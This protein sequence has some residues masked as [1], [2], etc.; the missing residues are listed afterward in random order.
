MLGVAL[1]KSADLE[2]RTECEPSVLLENGFG[3][4]ISDLNWNV[5]NVL[6]IESK[7]FGSQWS[8]V[9]SLY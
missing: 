5:S 7:Q 1:G 9:E 2:S 4:Q 3:I 8:L 6:S